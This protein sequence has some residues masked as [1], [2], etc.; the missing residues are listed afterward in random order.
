MYNSTLHTSFT[1]YVNVLQLL[2]WIE[3]LIISKASASGIIYGGW[4]PYL[5]N[6]TKH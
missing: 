4:T 5:C 3:D 1:N 6:S 2:L